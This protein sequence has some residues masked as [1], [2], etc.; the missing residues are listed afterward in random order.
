MAAQEPLSARGLAEQCEAL[1]E[2]VTAQMDA[3]KAYLEARSREVGFKFTEQHLLLEQ[4]VAQ[5]ED[6]LRGEPLPRLR[7]IEGGRDA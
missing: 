5:L 1:L 6:G 3:R 2:R 4:L 7:L